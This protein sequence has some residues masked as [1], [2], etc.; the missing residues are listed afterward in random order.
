MIRHNIGHSIA[1][2]LHN[3]GLEYRN[4]KNYPE[5]GKWLREA[6]AMKKIVHRGN[7][8]E[9]ART[10]NSI[11]L[12]YSDQGDLNKAKDFHKQAYDMIMACEG[13][14][15]MKSGIKRHLDE[16]EKSSAKINNIA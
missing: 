11:G 12:A 6:L 1:G 3:I 2:S 14:D 5:S 7:H 15:D 8:P 4:L 9:T 16:T 13:H 10:L